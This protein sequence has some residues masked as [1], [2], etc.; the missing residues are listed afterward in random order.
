M[1]E[2]NNEPQSMDSKEIQDLSDSFISAHRAME[3]LSHT[4]SQAIISLIKTM[5]IEQLMLPRNLRDIL[6]FSGIITIL[7]RTSLRRIDEIEILYAFSN[8][9]SEFHENPDGRPLII[10]SDES[11]YRELRIIIMVPTED[12]LESLPADLMD[13]LRHI[14]KAYKEF[15]GKNLIVALRVYEDPQ[16]RSA[17]TIIP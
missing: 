15:T 5:P 17:K 11:C 2:Q 1:T 9:L 13:T 4:T 6:A 16:F 8:R 14:A 3:K 12:D 7:S 10:V